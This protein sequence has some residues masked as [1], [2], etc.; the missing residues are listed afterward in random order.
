MQVP[1]S[2]NLCTSKIWILY[3]WAAIFLR[4]CIQKYKYFC[5]VCNRCHS[6]YPEILPIVDWD[7]NSSNG[8]IVLHTTRLYLTTHNTHKRQ[9]FMPSAGF[10]PAIPASQRPHTHALDRAATGI[11]GQFYLDAAKWQCTHVVGLVD[12]DTQPVYEWKRENMVSS[13][14]IQYTQ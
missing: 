14:W 6:T 5:V 8:R 13:L 1:S 2:G 7:V 3:V 4:G 9:T 12:T 10:E 11:G